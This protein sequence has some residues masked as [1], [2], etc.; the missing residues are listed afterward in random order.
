MKTARKNNIPDPPK[1]LRAK[2]RALWMEILEIWEMTPD[3]LAILLGACEVTD[4]AERAREILDREEP[5]FKNKAGEPVKH[6][7]AVVMRDM[8]AER[9]AAIKQLNLETEPKRP[10]GR[11]PAGHLRSH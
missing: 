1:H 11:P 3:S 6:P 10:P 7:A 9:R 5:T 8:L 2:G 4:Q